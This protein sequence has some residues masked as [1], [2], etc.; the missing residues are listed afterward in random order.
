MSTEPL[1]ERN[2]KSLICWKKVEPCGSQGTFHCISVLLANAPLP[3]PG[4]NQTA[5]ILANTQLHI[6]GGYMPSRLH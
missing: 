6:L 2:S 5:I 1:K 3:L 4:G